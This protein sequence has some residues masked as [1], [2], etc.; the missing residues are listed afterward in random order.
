MEYNA[1]G[2]PKNPPSHEIDLVFT[3]MLAGPMDY[4]PGILS[5]T[6]RGGTPIPSTMARQLALY[7]LL[8]SPIQMAADLP[9]N[10]AKF[11]EAF[12]FIKDVPTDW[13]ESRVLAGA[14]GEFAVIARKDRNSRDWYL[15]AGTD[16]SAREIWIT[17]D[18]LEPGRLY[19][20]QIYR[21]A[22]NGPGNWVT[23]YRTEQRTSYLLQTLNVGRGDRF[24]VPMAPGGGM[25][26]RF[27]AL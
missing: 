18:F 27:R 1:W 11:P 5:L 14:V 6:G 2:D 21:D 23:D 10:Y 9:E 12:Q 16:E 24:R 25:A 20:A 7:V 26:V 8:Y 17:L 3:R 4:T 22:E 19:Q 15:G 13:D